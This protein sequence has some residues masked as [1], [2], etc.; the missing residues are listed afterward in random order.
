MSAT[1]ERAWRLPEDGAVLAFL[2]LLLGVLRPPVDEFHPTILLPPFWGRVVG[3]RLRLAS[4]H[5]QQLRR[6]EPVVPHEVLLDAAGPALRELKVVAVAPH[7]IGVPFD[8]NA[9]RSEEHT[10]ELQSRQYLVCRLLL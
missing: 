10:S 8:L 5:G 3:D 1:F 9:A 6:G 4:P 2:G 7:A